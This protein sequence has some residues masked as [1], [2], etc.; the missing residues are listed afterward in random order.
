MSYDEKP[1]IQA[2]G[3]TCPD[4]NPTI[5][6]GFVSRDS[7]Y[8]RH[9]TLSLLAAIDLLT[10]EAIPLIRDTHKSSDFIAFYRSWIIIIPNRI[11]SESSGTTTLHIHQEK[12]E[13]FWQQCQ[14]E[15]LNCALS[16]GQLT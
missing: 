7:E 1:G 3:N 13:I 5:E 16:Q 14:M 6:H 9:G 11:E 8:V 12:P 15:D 10:G 2:I 4:W